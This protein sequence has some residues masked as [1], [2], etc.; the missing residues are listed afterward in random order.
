MSSCFDC[1]TPVAPGD[2]FCGNCGLALQPAPRAEG[3]A[4]SSP[5]PRSQEFVEVGPDAPEAEARGYGDDLQ[6]TIIEASS[7]GGRAAAPAREVEPAEETSA[8]DSPTP[9]DSKGLSTAG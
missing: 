9:A 8:P 3:G 5:A 6:P 1:G 2:R 4:A 7:H